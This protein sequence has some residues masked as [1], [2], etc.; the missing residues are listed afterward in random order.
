MAEVSGFTADRMLEIEQ[1]AI[2]AGAIVGDDLILEPKGFATAPGTYPKVNA[3]DVR[4]PQGDT[5]PPGEVTTAAMNAAIASAHADGAILS[6]QLANSAVIT[7]KINDGAVTEPKIATNAVTQN[8]LAD[9]SVITAKI[10]DSALTSAKY[11]NGS[12]GS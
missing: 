11:A 1:S 2:V 7:A 10:A 5:G 6:A 9:G 4:G 8:K 12:V 3:G